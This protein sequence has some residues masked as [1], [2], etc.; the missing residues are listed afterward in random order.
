MWANSIPEAKKEYWIW[1][2]INPTKY[3]EHGNTLYILRGLIRNRQDGPRFYQQGRDYQKLKSQVVLVYRIETLPPVDFFLK[4]INEDLKVWGHKNKGLLGIQLDY[5]SPS[6]KLLVYATFINEVRARLSKETEL[7]ITGLADWAR[8]SPKSDLMNLQ[9]AVNFIVFQ[10]Y[11]HG[12]TYPDLIERIKDLNTV[13]LPYKLG[14]VDES[15]GK[16]VQEKILSQ[17]IISTIMFKGK[18]K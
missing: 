7:S 13:P 4:I 6:S 8:H 2:Q 18:N 1:P 14:V 15:S 10:L 11:T 9:K 17:K 16:V 3:D 12:Y 5:D